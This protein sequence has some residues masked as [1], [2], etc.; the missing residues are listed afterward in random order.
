MAYCS[1]SDVIALALP[2]SSLSPLTA[3]QISS[4]CQ[5]VSDFM[6]GFFRGRWGYASVPLL[7]W[8]TSVTENAAKVSAFRLM[9]LRGMKPDGSDWKLFESVYKEALDWLNGVQ[10]QQVH[11]NVTLANGALPGQQ[12]PNLLTSSAV[13]LATGGRA[14][15]RG[16]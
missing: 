1:G 14:R 7:A 2:I 10:R 12:Q 5:A 11:P 16:W 8:D 6:D 4:T 3:L 9:R 13:D 15:N